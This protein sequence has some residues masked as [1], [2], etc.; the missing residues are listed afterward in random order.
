MT[1]TASVCAYPAPVVK[2][3]EPEQPTG[4]ELTKN[5]RD[6][7]RWRD[8][9][10]EEGLSTSEH[11]SPHHLVVDVASSK[12]AIAIADA[13]NAFYRQMSSA[14]RVSVM[15]NKS[16]RPWVSGLTPTIK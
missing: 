3:A 7:L 9:V 11:S 13:V 12:E 16:F 1:C 2:P 14:R 15:A 10:D 4:K 8:A 6:V 5:L